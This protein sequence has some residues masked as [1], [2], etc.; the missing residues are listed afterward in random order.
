M[1]ERGQRLVNIDDSHLP[2]GGATSSNRVLEKG[3][4]ATRAQS[5]TTSATEWV[6]QKLKAIRG[7]AGGV[8]HH[9]SNNTV[10]LRWNSWADVA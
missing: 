4:L 6:S 1:I 9:F 3:D 2:G 10:R 7:F 8:A 5:R